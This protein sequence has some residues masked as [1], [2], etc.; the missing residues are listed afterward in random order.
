MSRT[1]AAPLRPAVAGSPA[2]Q[3][4]AAELV[5]SAW[6]EPRVAE[7][8]EAEEEYRAQLRLA[9]DREYAL[10]ARLGLRADFAEGV[11]CAIGEKR[12]ET[13]QWAPP[14]LAE[15]R[16]DVWVN[17]ALMEAGLRD[18]VELA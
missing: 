17:A 15:A 16:G 10:N 9:L 5:A 3:L 6:E 18:S 2:A 7:G 11:A 14:T 8:E 4:C 1:R 12:G 13:P